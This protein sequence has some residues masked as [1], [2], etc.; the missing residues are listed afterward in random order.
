MVDLTPY[1]GYLTIVL[2]NL[3]ALGV[4]VWQLRA[5]TDTAVWVEPPPTRTPAP[6]ATEERLAVY[7]SGAVAT[8]GVVVLPMGARAREAVAAAGGFAG[9]ADSAAVNLAAPLADG[10]QLHVPA[11]GESSPPPAGISGGGASSQSVHGP[12]SAGS[13]VDLGSAAGPRVNVNTATAA[14]LESLPGVGPALAGRIVAHREKNGP[15]VSAE[16][17]LAVSGI[18][19]KTLARF[20]DRIAVR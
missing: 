1:R 4:I 12:A 19:E 11:A 13:S 2:V 7:V 14:E 17:L 15:F 5:P 10:Q 20:V 9:E 3:T 6:T 18:G 8:P 16:G